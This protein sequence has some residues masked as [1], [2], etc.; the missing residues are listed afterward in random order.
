MIYIKITTS[1]VYNNKNMQFVSSDNDKYVSCYLMGGLGNQLFQ[2]FTTIAYGFEND[3]KVVFPYTKELKTGTIRNTYW[4]NFLGTIKDS[5]T[6]LNTENKFKNEMISHFPAIRETDFIYQPIPCASNNEIL[7]FGYFQSYKYFEE[8]KNKIFD[9]IHLEKQQH[10]VIQEVALELFYDFEIRNISMH[11]RIGDY[12]KIQDCHPLMSYEYYEKA[13]K[14]IISQKPSHPYQVLYFHE[15]VDTADVEIIVN[16]LKS[17]DMFSNI[18]FVRVQ[19]NLD[20]WQQMLL[21]S[22]CTHNIIANSTFSWWG[23]YFNTYSDK[24]ICYPS[25]WFGQK[26]K[27]NTRDLFPENWNKIII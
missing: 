7:L 23:A 25:L 9:L 1:N 27:H 21:M 6:V 16:K 18:K 15:D 4:D 26:L 22:C 12:K 10:Q 19:H 13:L 5:H 2:I 20:D 14:Y 24:I 3:R 8:S 17:Q 11:F